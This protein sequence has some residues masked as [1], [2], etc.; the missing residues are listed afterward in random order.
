MSGLTQLGFTQTTIFVAVAVLLPIVCVLAGLI[1]FRGTQLAQKKPIV[2][3]SLGVMCFVCYGFIGLVAF[4][5]ANN[6]MKGSLYWVLAI[7]WLFVGYFQYRARKAKTN[8]TKQH[9]VA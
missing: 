7:A 1:I 6:I 9:T 2:M 3:L 8:E 4:R 5:E